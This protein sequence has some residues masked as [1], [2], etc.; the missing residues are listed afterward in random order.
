[1]V[2]VTIQELPVEAD[3]VHPAGVPTADLAG[4]LEPRREDADAPPALGRLVVRGLNDVDP[5][6]AGAL[7]ALAVAG[8]RP[9]AH[10]Q[11]PARLVA[12]VQVV[13]PLH[14]AGRV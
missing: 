11:R 5:R 3:G 12:E 4:D 13:L 14:L 7:V 9:G 2:P 6:R 1:V 8:A 10:H